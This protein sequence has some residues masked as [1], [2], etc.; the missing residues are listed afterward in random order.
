ML[1]FLTKVTELVFFF[2]AI[3]KQLCIISLHLINWMLEYLSI[4]L[5]VLSSASSCS[6]NS[7]SDA[8]CVNFY[9]VRAQFN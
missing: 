7:P 5:A 9:S 2:F 1:H 3:G 8:A 4:I 6:D